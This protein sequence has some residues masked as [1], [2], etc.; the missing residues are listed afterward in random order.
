M[1]H[2]RLR[3][4]A[5]RALVCLVLAA[6]L[7]AGCGGAAAPAS[8]V[9]PAQAQ[10]VVRAYFRARDA[11]TSQPA[12]GSFSAIESPPQSTFDNGYTQA[13]IALGTYQPSRVELE[14]LDV[15]VPGQSRY[16][17]RFLSYARLR[18]GSTTSWGINDFVKTSAGARWTCDYANLL[19]EGADPPRLAVAGDGYLEGAPAGG[20]LAAPPARFGARVAAFFDA[21]AG[22]RPSSLTLSGNVDYLLGT[23]GLLQG[24]G[25]GSPY[26]PTTQRYSVPHRTLAYRLRSGGVLLL[27]QLAATMT[28][29]APNGSC[30]KLGA[31]IPE[32]YQVPTTPFQALAYQGQDTLIATVERK[33]RTPQVTL[34]P[35]QYDSFLVTGA[36]I[37]N[38][39]PTS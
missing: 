11:L 23:F 10:R 21:R 32:D 25:N 2:A 9:T 20:R 26:G 12:P 33:G 24:L 14:K 31:P 19:P 34:V 39:C 27:F 5:L 17:L 3:A 1:P 36:H 15:Y 37:T 16:P 35:T 18:S 6:T 13:A 29:T 28:A 38:P 22:G 4:P 30:L 7:L 8:P